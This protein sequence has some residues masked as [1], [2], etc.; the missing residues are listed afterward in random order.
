MNNSILFIT[1]FRDIGRNNWD[2]IPRTYESYCDAFY[3]YASRMKYNIVVFVDETIKTYLETNYKITDNVFFYDI[4]NY[5][6]FYNKYMDIEQKIIN[7]DIYKNKI[8]SNRKSC[9]EHLYSEYNLVNH[10]K[11]NY[12]NHAKNIFNDYT[13]YSWI[14]FGLRLPENSKLY[15]NIDVSKIPNKI[16][17]QHVSSNLSIDKM[18]ILPDKE[19]MTEPNNMLSSDVIYFAGSIFIINN[20]LVS[21]YENLYNEKIQ[22]LQSKNIVDDD[23]NLVLQLYLD[24]KSLFFMPKVKDYPYINIPL[25]LE[26]WFK[27]YEFF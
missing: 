4:N 13:F 12:V 5:D 10:S 21:I 8:P 17:Y 19:T 25:G 11:I 24:N 20:E 3:K 14:D 9:P 2:S 7:S 16:I 1:A 22:E 27:L 23:Q 18:Y 15:N 6:S 26:E